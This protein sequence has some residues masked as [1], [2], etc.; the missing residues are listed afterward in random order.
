DRCGAHSHKLQSRSCSP[1]YWRQ[2]LHNQVP[3]RAIDR[4]CVLKRRELF[5]P[6]PLCRNSA[7]NGQKK[8]PLANHR[9]L[10]LRLF[11]SECPAVRP[12]ALERAKAVP[13]VRLECARD[14]WRTHLSKAAALQCAIQSDPGSRRNVLPCLFELVPSVSGPSNPAVQALL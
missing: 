4:R 12:K 7:Q 6:P 11:R 9:V 10:Q 14:G 5:P 8:V 1:L 2:Q 3:E 13:E